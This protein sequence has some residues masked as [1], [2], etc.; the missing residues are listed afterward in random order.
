MTVLLY[1]SETTKTRLRVNLVDP[2]IVRTVLRAQGFP[3]EDRETL[4]PPESVAPLFVDLA[5]PDCT[6]H[7]E[8]VEAR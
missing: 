4:P 8:I 6:R 1:A 5:A 7:G 2:G 3:G